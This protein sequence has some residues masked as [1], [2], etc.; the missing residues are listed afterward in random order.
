VKK[1]VKL[2]KSS[3]SLNTKK[4]QI[5]RLRTKDILVFQK[6]IQ[7]FK[8]VFEMKGKTNTTKIHLKKLLGNS[9]FIA[10]VII[11]ENKIV[12]GL[13]AYELQKYYSEESEIFIYDIAIKQKFQRKGL[14][15]QLLFTLREYCAA[16]KIKEMFV[17]ANE[18][19]E[20][21]LDFYHSSG[22]TPEKV[23]CF[24]YSF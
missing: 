11:Y 8:E 13:T 7:L 12:G 22:A 23:V 17:A 16:N 9:H 4:I 5:K 21:A 10:Y 6:L 2:L 24:N 3:E 18:E 1:K 15:K 14:G 19:D 20:H